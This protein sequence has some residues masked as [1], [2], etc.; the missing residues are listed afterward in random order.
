MLDAILILVIYIK[1]KL[2]WTPWLVWSVLHDSE[3]NK[4]CPCW[5]LVIYV[6]FGHVVVCI[7]I[8]VKN[9]STSLHFV[10]IKVSQFYLHYSCLL[11]LCFLL[12]L[13][14]CIF[15]R[16][17]L[18]LFILMCILVLIIW[19]L[20]IF[21]YWVWS[22]TVVKLKLPFWLFIRI[23]I[24]WLKNTKYRFTIFIFSTK[25]LQ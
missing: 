10:Q 13:L 22:F 18:F 8:L 2:K 23:D 15:L 1:I 16:V 12:L 20:I 21:E 25:V 5:N 7:R 14:N 4:V 19:L 9:N 3:R 17:L 6:R 24:L 11:I